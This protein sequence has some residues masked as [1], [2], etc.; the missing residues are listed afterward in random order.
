MFFYLTFIQFIKKFITLAE[1]SRFLTV[2]EAQ[3]LDAQP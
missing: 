1:A 3:A 2:Q